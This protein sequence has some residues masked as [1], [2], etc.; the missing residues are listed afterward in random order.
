[1]M[2]SLPW[3][4]PRRLGDQPGRAGQEASIA[5]QPASIEGAQTHVYKSIDGIDLRLHVF[6]PPDHLASM[7]RPAIVFV[8]GV[9]LTSEVWARQF[10]SIP[11]AGFRAVAF[12]ADD[13]GG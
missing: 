2:S 7:K 13:A 9:T 11:A 1:M 4:S 8:H 6:S 3:P 5:P 10:R 12:D